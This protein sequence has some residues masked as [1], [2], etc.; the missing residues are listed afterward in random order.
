MSVWGCFAGRCPGYALAMGKGDSKRPQQEEL[1]RSQR[2]QADPRH[3]TEREE[4]R[5]APGE[6]GR[7]GPVPPDNRP[8]HRPPRDQDKPQGPPEGDREP[9]EEEEGSGEPEDPTVEA[10]QADPAQPGPGDSEGSRPE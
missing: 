1:A 9:P 8:G 2:S 10:D 7:A 4:A 6:A 3:W 5:T